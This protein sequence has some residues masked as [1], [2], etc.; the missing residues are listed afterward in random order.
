MDSLKL[1][2]ILSLNE[3]QTWRKVLGDSRFS[4]VLGYI[5]SR[6]VDEDLEEFSKQSSR[7]LKLII[8]YLSDITTKT[9]KTSKKFITQKEFDSLCESLIDG[10]MYETFSKT[11]NFGDVATYLFVKRFGPIPQ[12]HLYRSLIFKSTRRYDEHCKALSI[13]LL[14]EDLKFKVLDDQFSIDDTSGHALDLIETDSPDVVLFDNSI[15]SVVE[16]ENKK[17][18]RPMVDLCYK[19]EKTLSGVMVNPET[20]RISEILEQEL[21]KTWILPRKDSEI[22]KYVL[23]TGEFTKIF[24]DAASNIQREFI[25][26]LPHETNDIWRV[27]NYWPKVK[28]S[29][30]NNAVKNISV[31][32]IINKL[33]GVIVSSSPEFQSAI[34]KENMQKSV[35]FIRTGELKNPIIDEEKIKGE[36]LDRNLRFVLKAAQKDID[37][38]IKKSIQEDEDAE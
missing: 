10:T 38:S 24:K 5:S 32:P 37:K 2:G 28:Y 20:T 1:L 4:Q 18:L 30:L 11:I 19:K 17:L 27:N 29:I 22:L 8:E 16:S 25:Y 3:I 13:E 21:D 33:K 36:I 34:L 23:N 6:I 9:R 35:H 7:N 31:I 15:T 26:F 14:N 12:N